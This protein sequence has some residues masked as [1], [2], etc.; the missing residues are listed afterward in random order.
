M[1]CRKRG[2]SESGIMCRGNS[3]PRGHS[4]RRRT[5]ELRPTE[6][7]LCRAVSQVLLKSSSHSSWHRQLGFLLFSQM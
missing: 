5:S 6:A 1:A 2:H 3:S 7:H 4:A